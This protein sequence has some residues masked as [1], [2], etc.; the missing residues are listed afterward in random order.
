MSF[1]RI[2]AA[3]LT[4]GEMSRGYIEPS[5]LFYQ[6]A[7]QRAHAAE[8]MDP[9]DLSF[10]RPLNMLP[11]NRGQDLGHVD[12]V[13]AT[14]FSFPGGTTHLTVDEIEAAAESGLQVGVIHMISPVNVGLSPLS[15]RLLDLVNHPNVSLFSLADRVQT[16][17]M[18]VRHATVLQYVENLTSNV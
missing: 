13:F 11:G 15:G 10:P 8:D 5:R 3:S 17:L 14:D 4:V 2:H 1:S 18:V 12:V 9:R 7:Y 6:A 16:D